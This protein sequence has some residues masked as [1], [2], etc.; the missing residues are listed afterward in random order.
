[1][2][3]WYLLHYRITTAKW[4]QDF[5]KGLSEALE[6]Q[7]YINIFQIVL[8]SIWCVSQ[9]FW[10]GLQASASPCLLLR[11]TGPS[12]Q[13]FIAQLQALPLYKTS[14]AYLVC[15]THQTCKEAHFY[16]KRT[17]VQYPN[18]YAQNAYMSVKNTACF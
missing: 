17:C 1:M 11:N 3:F 10:Q 2:L 6:L 15:H 13:S 16:R 18:K 12:F 8:W 5:M 14:L 4:K 9:T 7:V